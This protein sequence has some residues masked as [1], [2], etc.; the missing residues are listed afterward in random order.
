MKIQK[1]DEGIGVLNSYLKDTTGGIRNLKQCKELKLF[2]LVV[3][4]TSRVSTTIPLNENRRE[5]MEF[6]WW[7]LI[8]S[9]FL[10]KSNINNWLACSPDG[11]FIRKLFHSAE[12]ILYMSNFYTNK[13][14][15]Q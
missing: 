3:D 1:F 12:S 14:A 10:V 2:S 8:G 11:K 7:S 5:A 6:S 4:S 13:N 9:E 15:F